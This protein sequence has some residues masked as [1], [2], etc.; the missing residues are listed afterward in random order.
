[1][2]S[3]ALPFVIYASGGFLLF[4]LFCWL[5]RIA[6]A[7][8]APKRKFLID[9]PPP[10]SDNFFSWLPELLRIPNHA[11]AK[12]AG[13]DA[14]IVVRF[15]RSSF[16]F[17]LL[18]SFF[19]IVVI[20][21]VNYSGGEVDR[22]RNTPILVFDNATNSTVEVW[23]NQTNATWSIFGIDELTAL[24]RISIE[25]VAPDSW[26]S[27]L[28]IVFAVLF[29]ILALLNVRA[30]YG[31][32]IGTRVQRVRKDLSECLGTTCGC[33]EGQKCGPSAAVEGASVPSSPTG[34]AKRALDVASVPETVGTPSVSSE[35]S[36][37][38]TGQSS[39]GTASA[40][41]VDA[42]TPQ[43]SPFKPPAYVDDTYRP[44]PMP[45]SPT[46]PRTG[47]TLAVVTGQHNHGQHQTSEQKPN[48]EG[49]HTP[50]V[51]LDLRS[52]LCMNLPVALRHPY[53]LRQYFEHTLKFGSGE[54]E[55]VSVVGLH[56]ELLKAL[57]ERYKAV[58]D[59]ERAWVAWRGNSGE[60]KYTTEGAERVG[61]VAKMLDQTR[62][63]IESDK[64]VG[65]TTTVAGDGKEGIELQEMPPLPPRPFVEPSWW[66]HM[67][68]TI[69]PGTVSPTELQP[70]DQLSEAWA[71]FRFH[72]RR[73][74]LL[75]KEAI[76]CANMAFDGK[77]DGPAGAFTEEDGMPANK[78]SMPGPSSR[79][80]KSEK[81]AELYT[82]S[83]AFVTF[84]TARSAALAAQLV[85]PASP[86]DGLA[87]FL[88]LPAPHPRDLYWPNLSSRFST[89]K[90]SFIRTLFSIGCLIALVFF[91]SVPIG[92]IASF[93]S[94]ENLT[95]TFPGFAE[96]AQDLPVYVMA[97]FSKSVWTFQ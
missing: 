54:V 90:L 35:G 22:L 21:P 59:V 57:S 82:G 89:P 53:A 5:R 94:V 36:E 58:N 60:R 66:T 62:K 65:V 34:A 73:V 40:T 6:P 81:I 88:V 18:L 93:L 1:M 33:V 83:T 14:L 30:F 67:K 9:P 42:T 51:A 27:D 10:L 74:H 8:F 95:A 85:L 87:S 26:Q 32:S 55:A 56:S 79:L 31:E 76:E 45:L 38:G 17:F 29:Q 75:R 72:N 23:I 41:V 61:E 52:V 24:R 4:L 48:E 70:H 28:H 86:G 80:T 15:M 63:E 69:A 92:M 43:E 64:L 78:P 11:I 77:C 50:H 71:R 84:K 49:E 3:V 44:V 20:L 2:T 25:N 47:A 97:R 7:T 13:T 12:A 91:W 68:A 19:S 46:N 16:V 39:E 37:N 96:L